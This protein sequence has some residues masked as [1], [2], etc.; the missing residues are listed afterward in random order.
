MRVVLQTKCFDIQKSPNVMRV[1]N[2]GG[3]KNLRFSLLLLLHQYKLMTLLLLFIVLLL[4]D[5]D[6]LWFVEL[7]N[8]PFVRRLEK[9]RFLSQKYH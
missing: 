1:F 3:D 9:F 6:Y 8:F 4:D 5:S 7:D 2:S